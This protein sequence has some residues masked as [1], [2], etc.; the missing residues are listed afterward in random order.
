MQKLFYSD[1]ALIHKSAEKYWELGQILS[2]ARTSIRPGIILALLEAK[3]GF[4][5]RFLSKLF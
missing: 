4:C 2:T 1:K 3:K 5:L